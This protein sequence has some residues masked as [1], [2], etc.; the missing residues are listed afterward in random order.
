MA[1]DNF[2]AVMEEIFAHEGGVSTNPKDLGN[3]TGGK[4]GAGELLGT[5]YGIAA[6]A[7]PAIDIPRLTKAKA[8]EIYRTKYWNAVRGDALRPGL[9]LVTM[10]PAVNS[11]VSRGVRWLQ[12]ALRVRQDGMM[13]PVTLT[14]A[15]GGPDP[16]VVIAR[17]C[18][19]RMGFLRGLRTWSTFGRGW[20]RRVASVEAVATRMVLQASGVPA[21]PTLIAAKDQATATARRDEAAAGGSGV[22]GAGGVGFAN[23]P[24]WALMVV[25][26]LVVAFVINQL[27]RARSQK[28]RADAFQAA[29]EGAAI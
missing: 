11:G 6:H 21:R 27:G 24:T 2:Q 14:A 3:W 1:K 29:A 8:A 15:N 22:V 10:D 26:A 23:V 13:G 20:S 12:A 17:A 4:V 5:K 7:N 19:A 18:A 9:D 16:V 28:D 25:V